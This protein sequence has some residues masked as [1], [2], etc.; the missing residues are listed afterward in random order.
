MIELR[1]AVEGDIPAILADIR[2]ADVDE[3]VAGGTTPER[4]LRD[5]LRISDWTGVALVGGVPCCMFGVAPITMTNGEGA[6]WLLGTNAII[7]HQ[8][9]LL[10]TCRPVIGAMRD[11]YPRLV[12]F[13]DERN[14]VAIRWLRWL[15]F[16]F[17]DTTYPIGGTRFRVFR[18]GSWS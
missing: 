9:K 2:Q 11:S 16:R 5:G 3:M 7:P 18:M 4:A 12:N 1:D 13:V 15:G 14:T 6:P 17:D 8:K 10:R